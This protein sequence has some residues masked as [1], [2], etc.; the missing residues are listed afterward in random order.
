MKLKLVLKNRTQ[1]NV[2]V[3]KLDSVVN[4]FVLVLLLTLF[5][6]EILFAQTPSSVQTTKTAK[7]K[8]RKLEK[9]EVHFHLTSEFSYGR[10]AYDRK[11][12][13]LSESN[14]VSLKPS[15]SLPNNY[16]IAALFEYEQNLK[17]QEDSDF[18]DLSLLIGK[19]F[20]SQPLTAETNRQFSITGTGAIPVSKAS[21]R[22]TSLQGS[23]SIL[24][25]FEISPREKSDYSYSILFGLSAV[26]FFHQ[27]ETTA[28]GKT[29]SSYGSNQSVTLGLIGG[30]LSL[31]LN[32]THRL[33]ISYQN[34]NKNNF[35]HSQE[36]AYR[37][38]DYST[39]AIGHT[40][41]GITQKPTGENN[42]RPID[43]D[44]SLVYVTL[45]INI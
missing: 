29:N 14:I 34:T 26:K 7:P 36:L 11:D 8:H 22:N 15:I 31:A 27:Y 18:S 33:R 38:S 20:D 41:E 24:G 17:N 35:I 10:N 13:S 28:S 25:N 44:N 21:I 39:L 9:E 19:S 6:S 42:I 30:R 1:K 37:M 40:L 32:F 12:G 23:A 45:G 43:E 3:S 5:S 16:A 2:T 4:T